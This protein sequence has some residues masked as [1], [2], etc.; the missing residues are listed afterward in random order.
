[1]M[2]KTQ[3]KLYSRPKAVC[4]LPIIGIFLLSLLML[5]PVQADERIELKR[6]DRTGQLS[7]KLDGREILV[8]QYG[9]WIDL[10]HYWPSLFC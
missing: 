7:V 6:D 5:S 2:N 4:L 8:Y 9:A 3:N 10:P 1:M